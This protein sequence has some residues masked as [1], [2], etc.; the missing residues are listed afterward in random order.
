MFSKL[1][2]SD[3][4]NFN[5]PFSVE[6]IES[7]HIHVYPNRGRFSASIDFKN[8][9]TEATQN[10]NTTNWDSLMLEMEQFVNALNKD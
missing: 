3:R 1:L 6:K 8:K 4:S 7:M 9:N 5:D 10:F 2:G